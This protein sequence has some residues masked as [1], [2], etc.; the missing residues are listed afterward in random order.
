M[1]VTSV[2]KVVTPD[3]SHLPQM[4]TDAG[5]IYRFVQYFTCN[6]MNFKLQNREELRDNFC[7][8]LLKAG[9]AILN[10]LIPKVIFS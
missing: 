3:E 9:L 6:S 8:L 10:G 2:A 7:G 5:S 1:P 4:Y